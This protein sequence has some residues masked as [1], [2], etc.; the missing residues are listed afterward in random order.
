MQAALWGGVATCIV[1]V[2][3]SAV[4]QARQMRRDD[5]DRISLVPWMSIQLFAI[6]AGVILAALA[7]SA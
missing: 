7:I 2:A 3:I 4:A 1:T 6:L 5:L